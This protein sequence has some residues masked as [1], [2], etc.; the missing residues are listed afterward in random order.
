M[1]KEVEILICSTEACNGVDIDE[2][3]L[4]SHSGRSSKRNRG[5]YYI[6]MTDMNS[7]TSQYALAEEPI[8]ENQSDFSIGHN[9]YMQAN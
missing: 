7:I 1:V 2:D 5:Y 6:A 4:I 9:S 8:F 3:K